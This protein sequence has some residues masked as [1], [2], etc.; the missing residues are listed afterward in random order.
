[1]ARRTI[2]GIFFLFFADIFL[3]NPLAAGAVSLRWDRFV[4]VIIRPPND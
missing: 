1:M 4:L 2:L 3:I